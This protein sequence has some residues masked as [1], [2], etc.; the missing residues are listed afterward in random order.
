MAGT[1]A[2]A[3]PVAGSVAAAGDSAPAP[4]SGS[5]EDRALRRF[6][7]WSILLVTS[8]YTFLDYWNYSRTWHEGST[9]WDAL[10]AGRGF[11]PAQYRIGVMRVAALLAS[12]T[13]THVRHMF[14]AIDFVC[15]AASLLVLFRLLMKSD[16]FAAEE[17]TA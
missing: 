5:V 13:H 11:A 6:V 2:G 16:A 10:L 3:E 1:L 4:F 17:R 9:E 12:L 14:A 8:G 7:G 15:L